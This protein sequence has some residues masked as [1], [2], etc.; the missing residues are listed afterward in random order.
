MMQRYSW[1][2]VL[3]LLH[4][5]ISGQ[6]CFT[7]TA[8]I[9]HE[10]CIGESDGRIDLQVIGGTPPFTYQWSNGATTQD[11]Q[12]VGSGSYSVTV[13]DAAG[14]SS[15]TISILERFNNQ[16]LYFIPDGNGIAVESSINVE[17][18]TSD[19]LEAGQLVAVRAELEHSWM[20]DLEITLSCPTGQEITLLNQATTGGEV[21]LGEP[22]EDDVSNPPGA[23]IGYFY[24]WAPFS[25]LGTMLNFANVDQFAGNILP[26]DYYAPYEDFGGLTGCD[27][28]GSWT[29]TITDMWGIDNGYLFSWEILFKTGETTTLQIAAPDALC[30][31]CESEFF[32]LPW[33]QDVIQTSIDNDCA[34]IFEYSSFS[35]AIWNDQTVFVGSVDGAPD[36]GGSDIFDCNGNL[37][38]SFRAGLGV[39]Y[40]PYPP[41]IT[42]VEEGDLI[43]ECGQAL[44]GCADDLVVNPDIDIESEVRSMFNDG[45]CLTISNYDQ[46]GFDQ[47]FGTFG[48]VMN[49]L[50]LSNGMIISTGM[51]AD[52]DQPNTDAEDSFDFNGESDASLSQLTAGLTINDAAGFEFDF[53]ATT[54]EFN[55]DL[56][57]ASEDYCEFSSQANFHDAIGIFLSG[58]GIDGPFPNNAVN[59][60][61]VPGTELPICAL[62][63]NEVINTNLFH[64]NYEETCGL[65][66]ELPE[67]MMFNGFT[68]RIS[69][70]V[71]V[72]PN[73]TYHLKVVIGDGLDGIYDSA[74]FFNADFSNANCNATCYDPSIITG[75]PCIS[76]Y[77]PVCGCNGVTYSNGCF[78]MEGGVGEFTAG[79]C[80]A[81]CPT[82]PAEILCQGWLQ[83]ILQGLSGTDAYNLRVQTGESGP[84]RFVIVTY[85]IIDNDYEQIYNCNGTWVQSCNG[86]FTP[87][88]CNYANPNVMFEYFTDFSNIT[89][90]WEES[91]PLPDDCSPSCGLELD[92]I[93]CM[94]WV[95]DEIAGNFGC[96]FPLPVPCMGDG[97]D[98]YANDDMIIFNDRNC[99]TGELRFF[100]CSGNSLYQCDYGFA[101]NDVDLDFS[102][103]DP[104]FLDAFENATLL[105]DCLNSDN[106]PCPDSTPPWT[107]EPC[108]TGNIHT[109]I[110]PDTLIS[111]IEGEALTPG[112]YIGV[113]YDSLGT[114]TV[115]AVAEWTGNATLVVCGDDPNTPEKEGF[116]ADEAF[117]VKV[118]KNGAIYNVRASYVPVAPPFIT[119]EGNFLNLGISIIRSL[120][121]PSSTGEELDC[122]IV[123]PIQCGDQLFGNSADGVSS[124]IS[125]NCFDA[126]VD[127]SEIVYEFDNPT[128]QNVLITLTDLQEDLELLLL[129][130]CDRNACL[131]VS[132]RTSTAPEAILYENLPAGI[133]YVVV[134]G[135]TGDESTYQ[136]ALECGVPTNEPM[137]CNP[138]GTLACGGTQFVSGTNANGLDNVSQYSC[139]ESYA[140]GKEV[141]YTFSTPNSRTIEVSLRPSEGDLD[142]FILDE[143]DPE[144]CLMAST[145]SGTEEEGLLLYAIANRTYYI[146]VDGYFG[147]ESA[148]DLSLVCYVPCTDPADCPWQLDCTD[149]IPI[150]CGQVLTGNTI[151]GNDNANSYSCEGGYTTGP[152]VVF[153]FENAVTQDVQVLL[154][155]IQPGENLD[156]Y[157]MNECD[158]GSCRT[159]Q[160]KSGN[161]DEGVVLEALP[162]GTYYIVVDGYDGS[163]SSFSLF[164]ECEETTQSCH[165]IQLFTGYNF[166][167]SYI[168]PLQKMDELFPEDPQSLISII[169]DEF[170]NTYSPRFATPDLIGEWDVTRGYIIKAT[171]PTTIE[172]CGERVDSLMPIPYHVGKNFVSYLK[173]ESQTASEVFC[174]D[175]NLV[176]VLNKQPNGSGGIITEPLIV[177]AG[178]VG[179]DFEM[180]PQKGYILMAAN[181]GAHTY[182]LDGG[183][184]NRQVQETDKWPR[185]EQ[186]H[187]T[188]A[189]HLVLNT[190]QLIVP[191]S[192]AGKL[193]APGDEVGVF[194]ETGQLFGSGHYVPGKGIALVINGNDDIY[195]SEKNGFGAGEPLYFKVWKRATNEEIPLEF[196]F[197]NGTANFQADRLRVVES[198]A[199]GGLTSA[200]SRET[201]A[202]NWSVFPN[203]AQDQFFVGIN[204]KAGDF[205][206]ELVSLD[207]KVLKQT[208]GALSSNSGLVKLITSDLVAGLY[209]CRLEINGKFYQ[210]KVAIIR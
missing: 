209:I 101:S 26:E 133:Y 73:Q 105:Q 91:Q 82:D 190:M 153:M 44:P 187:Y 174:D 127:G 120:R 90:I 50:D 191:A 29:L 14:C 93:L 33:L 116:A 68:D 170:G 198:A 76:V 141:V 48:G 15:D 100:D 122:S 129:T 192:V 178:C 84:D 85:N 70:P 89:T 62:N 110:I 155:D 30:T 159:L 158:V 114:E 24:G 92:E 56:V 171:E 135:Y 205:R 99:M 38:Q 148:F 72:E 136:I 52:I 154:S 36:G 34:S 169:E 150:E 140:S 102:N 156:L 119:A 12:S 49:T 98:L 57:F 138:L 193:L 145:K 194:D 183:G 115:S 197:V 17:G 64:S 81:N 176:Q 28:S 61:N 35:K 195:T 6:N 53:I 199:L 172:M 132:D 207:G 161:S 152:E 80:S 113:F 63:I 106:L 203:P 146:V 157:I 142:L 173:D 96:F 103:C 75:D 83:N 65:P 164:V 175:A 16:D 108:L 143:C 78:A 22:D 66:A 123:Y 118:Y 94:D 124:A 167:S 163:T 9:L 19:T 77:D 18:T 200:D 186:R 144:E 131:A 42:E 46:I 23:G 139:S 67:L 137:V 5:S 188:V 104:V 166:V 45:T 182:S 147:A 208:T 121:T 177:S 79:E 125:Y 179:I 112:D 165:E 8:E 151:H 168:D 204:G 31:T 126:L 41:I 162:A 107:P 7:L 43:W 20:R 59:L 21:F 88:T 86:G 196:T 201:Q 32:C 95:Q 27:L 117:V 60:A 3:L 71:Q 111:D 206:L 39:F 47:A 74:I 109:I 13:T 1:I 134:E 58:P 55:I 130:E 69:V 11:L 149:A 210:K 181:E 54:S 128:N 202:L 184:V 51:T 185:P 180:Y 87:W 4:F 37:L 2:S 10:S 25:T 40:E 97:L 189:N 160:N